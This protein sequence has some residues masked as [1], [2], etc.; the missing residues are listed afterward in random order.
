MIHTAIGKAREA[1][2][3]AA[4]AEHGINVVSCAWRTTGDVAVIEL[5]CNPLKWFYNTSKTMLG[6][7]V[8]GSI[9]AYAE[10]ASALCRSVAGMPE[11][12]RRFREVR[13]AIAGGDGFD[14]LFEEVSDGS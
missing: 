13:S 3:K 5:E 11:H 2:I 1:A 10:R 8:D 9:D 12:R 6:P 7:P 14:R 4:F